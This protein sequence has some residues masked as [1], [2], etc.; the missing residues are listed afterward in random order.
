RRIGRG[1]AWMRRAAVAL[2][3]GAVEDCLAL[4]LASSPSNRA[5]AAAGE[6]WKPSDGMWQSAHARP[7]PPSL[8]RL[9]SLKAARPRATASHGRSSQLSFVA[10]FPFEPCPKPVCGHTAAI[11]P[12]TASK[13]KKAMTGFLNLHMVVLLLSQLMIAYAINVG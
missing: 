11:A 6:S 12:M 2:G 8:L 3:A 9:R 7:F 1:A 5:S 4:L 10:P 13:L